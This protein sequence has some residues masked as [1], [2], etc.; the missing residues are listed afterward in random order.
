M[1]ILVISS[2]YQPDGGPAAPLFTMLCERLAMRG[3][4][5]TV[6]T[7][8]PHYPTGKVPQEFRG[9]KIERVEESGV[10][11]IRV[12]LPSINR[13]KLIL[14]LYQFLAFQARA[15]L[16]ARNQNCEVVIAHSPALEV[17]LPFTYLSVIRKKPVVY[18][19][20]DVYPDVGI[21]LG[22]FRSNLVINSVS[23][24]E[25]FCLKRASYIRILSDSFTQ[26]LQKMGI[27]DSKMFLI[28]DWVDTDLIKPISRKN[29]FSRKY[30]LLDS[31]VVL[32]A[33]N[34]GLSQGLETVLSAAELLV[35][36]T[37]IRFVFVGDGVSRERL[38]NDAINRGLEN[39]TFIP[40][41]PR[42]RLTEVLATADVSLV[43]LQSGIAFG[44]LPSKSFS[45]LASGRPVIASVDVDSDT[46]DLIERSQ[47]GLVVQPE[48]P[49]QLAEAITMLKNDPSLK[50]QLGKNGRE[51]VSKYHSAEYAAEAFEKLLLEAIG[52]H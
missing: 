10:H 17:W 15:T 32:Y 29:N 37:D 26:P 11:V 2:Y 9:R 20:H 45:I 35:D 34:I 31:F 40:F 44:S 50:V 49:K 21:S 22:I 38:E 41:Q 24:L 52:K 12:N 18:S 6:I 42:S 47:S 30:G 39:V 5:V 1:N 25:R 28:Y 36:Q 4:K 19:V 14:R 33:G 8:V 46:W 27:H 51:Y 43:V 23:T 48:N 16:A 3:H 7:G 13:N